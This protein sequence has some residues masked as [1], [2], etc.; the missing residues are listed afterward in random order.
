MVQDET[1]YVTVNEN[2]ETEIQETT[3]ID[4]RY[5]GLLSVIDGLKE[6]LISEKQKNLLLERKTETVEKEVRSELCDEFNNMMVEIESGWEQ[7]LQEEKDRASELSDWR[8]N[9][10]QEAYM[11]KRKKRKR[12]EERDLETESRE[13]GIKKEKICELDSQLEEEKKENKQLNEQ[14]HAMKEVHQ[15]S[16]EEQVIERQKLTRQSFQMA[17]QHEQFK[18]YKETISNLESDLKATNE[19][20]IVQSAEPKLKELEL[21]L[22][23]YKKNQLVLYQEKNNL[24]ALLDEAGE[25]YQAKDAELTSLREQLANLKVYNFCLMKSYFQELRN[26]ILRK[27]LFNIMY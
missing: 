24:T 10:M 6:Q 27:E 9:K 21:Q 18:G 26:I 7:R 13:L 19:A 16:M 4:Q 14:I 20:L 25:E 11:E 5:D 8:I 12:S 3:V 2:D 1:A 17:N 22:E 23:E 15:K